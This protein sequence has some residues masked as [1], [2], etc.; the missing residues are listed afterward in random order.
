MKQKW[1]KRVALFLTAATI[2]S[3]MPT[4]YLY[5]EEITE[6]S[7]MVS[8][9]KAGEAISADVSTET[10]NIEEDTEQ[11][12]LMTEETTENENNLENEI[13]TASTEEVQETDEYKEAD[14]LLNYLV[15]DNA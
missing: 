11:S 1:S 5:A 8:D 7:D 9:T 3:G 10:E 15:L 2:L 14:E 4:E 12:A 6:M 13:G